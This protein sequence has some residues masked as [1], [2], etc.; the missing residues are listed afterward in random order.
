MPA[1][2][3]L[4]A[5]L[6]G[7]SPR[8]RHLRR[9]RRLT[10][11]VRSARRWKN[12]RPQMQRPQ[13]RAASTRRVAGP[14]AFV[15]ND[16]SCNCSVIAHN[17]PRRRRWGGKKLCRFRRYGVSSAFIRPPCAGK[18]VGEGGDPRRRRGRGRARPA[19]WPRRRRRLRDARLRQHRARGPPAV[20]ARVPA[21]APPWSRSGP[22]HLKRIRHGV[23][24]A[25][26]SAILIRLLTTLGRSATNSE[27]HQRQQTDWRGGARGARRAL[28]HRLLSAFLTPARAFAAVP[29]MAR[30]W[31]PPHK[32]HLCLCGGGPCCAPPGAVRGNHEPP[33]GARAQP[34]LSPSLCGARSG[35]APSHELMSIG[36]KLLHPA[37]RARRATVRWS[38]L[39]AWSTTRRSTRST[40]CRRQCGRWRGPWRSS[41]RAATA[42]WRAPH[43][44]PAALPAVE[45]AGPAC[46]L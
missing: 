19:R 12:R 45:S 26:A 38:G 23:P 6:G 36:A 13:L 18:V 10:P 40:S 11:A 22:T 39:R 29:S 46:H 27:R 30:P 3:S 35:G 7:Q 28:L 34:V 33:G 4:Q 44:Q 25:R 24:G 16:S 14:G 31:A 9:R 15:P 8:R 41:R 43:R 17:H 32:T 21:D 20:A 37:P 42:A 2:P 1:R 5:R